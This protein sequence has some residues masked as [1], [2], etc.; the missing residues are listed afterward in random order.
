MGFDVIRYANEIQQMQSLVN[1]LQN[2][3]NANSVALL[4]KDGQHLAEA[5]ENL[6]TTNLSSLA[7]NNMTATDTVSSKLQQ[8]KDFSSSPGGDNPG[9]YISLVENKAVLIVLFDSRSSENLV[10]L[11]V[12]RFKDGAAS[13]FN[14]LGDALPDITSDGIDNLFE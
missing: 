7:G 5:G 13:I 1:R 2:D 4:D 6:D 9:V 11:R 3:A 10:K 8:G 12:R 14:Q